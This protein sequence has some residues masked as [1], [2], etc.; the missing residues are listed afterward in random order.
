MPRYHL[1]IRD[2]DRL[3]PDREGEAFPSEVAIKQQALE[4]AQGPIRMPSLMIP[5]RLDCTLEVT[6]SAGAVVL[7]LPFAEVLQTP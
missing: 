6:H 2:R 4:T 7:T 3:F 1:N 5:D